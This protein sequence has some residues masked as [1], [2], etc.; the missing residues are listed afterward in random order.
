MAKENIHERLHREPILT[1]PRLKFIPNIVLN[2]I[3]FFITFAVAGTIFYF[4][5]N[6]LIM[7]FYHLE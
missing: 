1:H 7:K 4:L 5:I 6:Y 2:L 3:S